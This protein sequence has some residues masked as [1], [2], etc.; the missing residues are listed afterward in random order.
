MH[1]SLQR[2]T[3]LSMHVTH[4]L[5]NPFVPYPIVGTYCQTRRRWARLTN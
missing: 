5:G 4:S 2:Q 3:S 1:E